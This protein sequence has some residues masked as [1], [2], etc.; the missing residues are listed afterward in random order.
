MLRSRVKLY[1]N[2][3]QA[4]KSR[5]SGQPYNIGDRCFKSRQHQFKRGRSG[6]C[7]LSREQAAPRS[8]AAGGLWQDLRDRSRRLRTSG[9]QL[10]PEGSGSLRRE[11]SCFCTRGRR[12]YYQ[13]WPLLAKECDRGSNQARCISGG[14]K[15]RPYIAS[16]G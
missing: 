10:R 3:Y 1:R 16:A 13:A 12:L 14:I 6:I 5:A 4:G 8:T 11:R 15:T 2:R 7:F 9:H